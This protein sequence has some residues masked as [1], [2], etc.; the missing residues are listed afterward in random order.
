LLDALSNRLVAGGVP[1]ARCW[2]HTRTLHPNYAGLSRIWQPGQPIV[3]RLLD[4]GF[5]QTEAYLRSP[6]RLV[7]AQRAHLRWRLDEADTAL[8]PVLAELRDAGH[9]DYAIWPVI[10]SDGAINVVSWTTREAAGFTAA[11]IAVLEGLLPVLA[12]TM[13]VKSLRRFAT[14]TLATYVGREPADLILHGQIRRGD[15]RTTTAA[16]MLVDLRDFTALSDMLPPDLVIETLNRYF[17]CVI[18]PVRRRGGEIIKFMG[19]AILVMFNEGPGRNA[20][21]ACQAAMDAAAEA[22]AAL[23][24]SNA[25]SNAPGLHA[26]FALHHGAVSYGNI[27]TGDR[28]DFTVIGPD[29]NL[30]SRIERLCRDIDRQV[31][32][33]ATFAAL[34]DRP[35]QEIGHFNIRGFARMQLLF[36]LPPQAA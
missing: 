33:S 2:L 10:Y 25:G 36:G 21:D 3:A 35:M 4:Y 22:L 9:R 30:T 20:R 5:E 32:M 23:N 24:H 12:M 1:I 14:N 26:W 29:V 28:L 18:P 16:L 19:D 34:I 15:V 13:E 31:V 17:D 6:V 8:L 11:Q 7:V 27:G